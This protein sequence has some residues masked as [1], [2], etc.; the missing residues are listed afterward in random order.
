MLTPLLFILGG[1]LCGSVLFARLAAGLFGKTA[2]LSESKD[3]KPGG[4]STTETAVARTPVSGA[5]RPGRSGK[6][7]PPTPPSGSATWPSGWWKGRL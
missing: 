6:T 7:S 5:I 2:I 3:A 1:Y 4:P